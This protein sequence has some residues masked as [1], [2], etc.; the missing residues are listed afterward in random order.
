MHMTY[1][2]HMESMYCCAKSAEVHMS[3]TCRKYTVQSGPV[4][5]ATFTRAL[6][7]IPTAAAAAAAYD[8]RRGGRV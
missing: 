6:I 4:H 8:R 5:M 2:C 3:G 7:I 1:I